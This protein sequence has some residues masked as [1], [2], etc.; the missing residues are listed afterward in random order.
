M[1]GFRRRLFV[2]LLGG[3]LRLRSAVLLAP[4]E[5]ARADR[6]CQRL[7]ARGLADRP[8]ACNAAGTDVSFFQNKKSGCPPKKRLTFT[9]KPVIL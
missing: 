7:C 1:C 4:N 9:A 2:R 8:L 5:S 3:I 6:A